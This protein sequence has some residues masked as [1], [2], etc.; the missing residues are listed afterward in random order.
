MYFRGFSRALFHLPEK[1]AANHKNQAVNLVKK[2]GL[3]V[4]RKKTFLVVWIS[5][6]TSPLWAQPGVPVLLKN[7]GLEV[8]L[9]AARSVSLLKPDI[10][11]QAELGMVDRA[12]LGMVGRVELGMISGALLFRN[13][14]VNGGGLYGSSYYIGCLGFF[15]KKELEIEKT[16]H[17]PLRV[18]LGSLEEVNRLEG[19]P[20]W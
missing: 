18:R 12:E 8:G 1:G 3:R 9:P 15:C 2:E 20:G 10:S 7:S 5:I 14:M 13:S 17:L 4:Q 16:T 11:G 19:K 6:L